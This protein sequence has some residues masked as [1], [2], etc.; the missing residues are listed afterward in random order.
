MANESSKLTD[1]VAE[2]DECN[3]DE[4]RWFDEEEEADSLVRESD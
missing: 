3:D 2:E 1:D 4:E